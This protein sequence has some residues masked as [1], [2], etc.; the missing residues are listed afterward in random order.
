MK[1]ELTDAEIEMV[2]TALRGIASD[3]DK[4]ESGI[5][6]GFAKEQAASFR[7]LEEKVLNQYEV[8]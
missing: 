4:P 7:A 6:S 2:L 3:W 5:P 1:L 8:D